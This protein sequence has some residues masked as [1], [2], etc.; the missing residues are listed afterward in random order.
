M[1]RRQF[2]LSSVAAVSASSA[3]PA[4]PTFL[5][6]MADQMRACDLGVS[7]NTFCRTPHLDALAA[8]GVRF[9]NAYCAQALCTPSRGSLLTG[10]YPHTSRLDANLYNVPSAFRDP[11]FKLTPNW[12][13]IL[14][15]A[16]YFTGYIG[17]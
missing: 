7:G 17:K 16:G 5:F 11:R 14:R 12:P 10:V 3:T 4:R 1:N 6:M 8:E 9:S 13:T 2:L 15:E